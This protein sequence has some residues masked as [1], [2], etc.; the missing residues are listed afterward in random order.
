MRG[1]GGKKGL[2]CLYSV[3]PG[4]VGMKD[5]IT[6]GI[7]DPLKIAYNFPQFLILTAGFFRSLTSVI[8]KTCWEISP[9]FKSEDTF[10]A[11]HRH[12]KQT[13][14]AMKFEF[15]KSK[16]FCLPTHEL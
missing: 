6:A 10:G 11:L 13:E 1:S 14:T 2:G 12:R 3:E 5:D 4:G 16:S 15:N 7:L 9:T 8:K